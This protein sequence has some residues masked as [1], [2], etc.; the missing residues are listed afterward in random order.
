MIPL[1]DS[2]LQ[3]Y[4][5]SGPQGQSVIQIPSLLFSWGLGHS[6]SVETPFA[7]SARSDFSGVGLSRRF[8]FVCFLGVFLSWQIRG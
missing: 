1:N 4:T 6:N 3:D 5:F 8:C 7:A 2:L